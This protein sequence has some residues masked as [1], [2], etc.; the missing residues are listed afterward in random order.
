MQTLVYT[1]DHPNPAS[2]A[3]ALTGLMDSLPSL[4]SFCDVPAGCVFVAAIPQGLR[5]PNTHPSYIVSPGGRVDVE[6]MV[7]AF[8]SGDGKEQPAKTFQPLDKIGSVSMGPKASKP[9]AFG[10]QQAPKEIPRIEVVDIE[11]QSPSTRKVETVKKAVAPGINK[12]QRERCQRACNVF[13]LFFFLLWLATWIGLLA[14]GCPQ[15]ASRHGDGH[16]IRKGAVIAGGV[17]GGLPIALGAVM[18]LV[19]YIL[20]A[21]RVLF[22]WRLQEGELNADLYCRVM[23]GK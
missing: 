17:I 8:R 2:P 9:Y 7:K 4:K 12:K 21:R 22:W 10:T 3:T 1:P 18:G 14:W 5:T 15:P 20:G 16:T 11:P 23:S 13:G 6:A 19:G